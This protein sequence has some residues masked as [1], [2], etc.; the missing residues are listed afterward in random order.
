MAFLLFLLL[1]IEPTNISTENIPESNSAAE[2]EC[3]QILAKLKRAKG[4]NVENKP[5]IKLV[6]NLPNPAFKLAMASTDGIIY[7]EER[8]YR[9]C[10]TELQDESEDALAF[11]IAHELAHYTEK[12]V[13]RHRYTD[14]FKEMDQDSN[15]VNL[16]SENVEAEQNQNTLDSLMAI[17]REIAT[18]HQIRNNEAEADLEAGFTAYLAG[19]HTK[20]AG[21]DFL[22]LVY[23]SFPDIS[24]SDD[25]YVS[26]D[27]RI[28]I[29]E[30]AG[31]KLDTLIAVFEAGN[32]LSMIKEYDLALQCYE[33]VSRSYQSKEL[34]NNMGVLAL[35][36]MM[37]EIDLSWMDVGYILP[38]NIELDLVQFDVEPD[39]PTSPGFNFD[40][41]QDGFVNSV[42]YPEDEAWLAS[43]SDFDGEINSFE[44]A[45]RT[46]PFDPCSFTNMPSKR[47]TVFAF[48]SALD[49]DQ[50]GETNQFELDN[51]TDLL[52]PCSVTNQTIPSNTIDRII[53]GVED[54]DGDGYSNEAEAIDGTDPFDPCSNIA[55]FIPASDLKHADVWNLADCD[56]DGEEN[57]LEVN[58]G[59]APF[60]PCSF[61][62]IPARSNKVYKTWSM[63]DCDGDGDPNG[64]ELKNDTDIFGPCST[65]NPIVPSE[66]GKYYEHWASADCDGDGELNS[67]EAKAR[68]NPFDACSYSKIPAFDGEIFNTWQFLD[69]DGDG[70]DNGW[71]IYTNTFV[72]SELTR[73]PIEYFN[74]A[75][76]IDPKFEVAYLNKSIYYFLEDKVKRKQYHSPTIYD[77]MFL[78]KSTCLEA[79]NLANH[80]PGISR[81]L[82]AEIY[83][84][85]AIITHNLNQQ[86][87]VSNMSSDK[88]Y[89]FIAQSLDEENDII[90]RN[91]K[92]IVNHDFEPIRKYYNRASSTDPLEQAIEE[93]IYFASESM[94]LK[95]FLRSQGNQWE[96]SVNFGRKAGTFYDIITRFSSKELEELNYSRLDLIKVNA[97]FA[98]NGEKPSKRYHFVKSKEN[99]NKATA[100]KIKLGD[101]QKKLEEKYE[102]SALRIQGHTRGLLYQYPNIIFN[103]EKK[104]SKYRVDHWVMFH[105]DKGE[106]ELE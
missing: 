61:T 18:R 35:K 39:I 30:R 33:Y 88:D 73:E 40:V 70:L 10:K 22:R 104:G 46:D 45:N 96:M 24:R 17:Y 23:E 90:K 49:C 97:G 19:Y 6:N 86:G 36:K 51:G 80:V 66:S 99:Y 16:L 77:E 9:L 3:I 28:M 65:S 101:T 55:P 52:D 27:E 72:V 100:R 32:Y 67:K 62:K 7:L 95:E 11:I 103:L 75:I 94:S 57:R 85:L 44:L 50:D 1:L 4:L 56:Q 29:A 25:K 58:N 42:D 43:D 48:W 59:T 15:F 8:T 13:V 47:D 63:I 14:K 71:E 69:C 38:V 91:A 102:G 89:I 5:F 64:S 12:H 74:D 78:A 98:F 54:C 60:E 79:K 41:D 21:P 93:E 2:D 92:Y 82:K 26:L 20:K 37:T 83:L 87:M 76:R 53:W 34:L 68:T 81:K 31:L 84:M 105:K 106:E